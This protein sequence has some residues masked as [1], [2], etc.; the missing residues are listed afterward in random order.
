MAVLRAE[1]EPIFCFNAGPTASPT[2]AWTAMKIDAHQHFWDYTR[3]AA[4]FVWMGEAEA[5]L[6]RDF[7]PM[8]LAPLLAQTGFDGSIAVQARALPQETDDLLG[9]AARHPTILGVVGW[10]DLCDPAIEPQIEASAANPL[11]KGLRMLI[12][13]QPDI[14]F[15][16][17]PA[18]LRGVALLQR[19]G[20]SYD[21]LLRPQHLGAAIRLVDAL[22]QQAFVV[23]HLAKPVLD[24]VPDPLWRQGIREIARRPNVFCKLSGLPTLAP[25][26]P[27]TLARCAPCLDAVLDAFGAARCMVGSDW[28]VSTL[29]ADYPA[30]MGLVTQWCQALSASEQADILGGTCARFYRV[31]A[32]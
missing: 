15:A 11:L 12:H 31:A 32:R 5:P 3:H 24:A 28:P 14:A 23:D 20:L 6:R 8:D 9:L 10:L 2:G 22:P 1:A 16:D 18:H 19:H 26:G 21:L 13:D 4:D 29:G 27:C 17:S 25:A 7:G 30:A